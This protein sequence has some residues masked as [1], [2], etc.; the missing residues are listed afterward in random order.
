MVNYCTG[1][2]ILILTAYFLDFALAWS[3]QIGTVVTGIRGNCLDGS[4]I[5][6]RRGVASIP[7][8]N[9]LSYKPEFAQKKL[10]VL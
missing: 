2:S 10:M 8:R 6:P 4:S 7:L 3:I 5:V 1:E 9:T